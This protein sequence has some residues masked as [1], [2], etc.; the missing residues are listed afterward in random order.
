VDQVGYLEDAVEW[1]RKSVGMDQ[2]KVVA[3]HRPGT[4]VDNIYSMS[5]AEVRTW[6]DRVQREGQSLRPPTPQFMYI[7]LP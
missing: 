7:W 1:A 3:Y 4:Y 6:L 2:A 5:S